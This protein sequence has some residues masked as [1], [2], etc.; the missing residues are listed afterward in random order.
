MN[1]VS[2]WQQFQLKLPHYIS[3]T[4]LN[5]PIGAFLLLWPTLWALWFASNG[6]PDPKLLLIF[7]AGTWLTRSAGCAIN[8]FADRDIDKH[9]RR[10]AERPI[11]SGKIPASDALWITAF[12]M[13]VAFILVL[14]TNKL[15]IALS[16]VA[17]I[18]ACVYPFTKR[19]TH[20]PQVVLG[21]AFSFAVPMAFAAQANAL[22]ATAWVIFFAAVVWAIAYDTFYA[23]A[24]RED[25]LRVGVKSTAIFFGRADLWVI[26]IA[27]AT[28]LSVMFWVGFQYDRGL[29]YFIGLAAAA[30]IAIRQIYITR[31]READK[32]FYAFL[33]NNYLGMVIFLGLAADYLLQG[34]SGT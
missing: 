27:Q 22:P 12:L 28:T 32:C 23:M 18:L 1:Q 24:D 15:T 25:D 29:L 9:I 8:D 19:Y 33:N 14:F 26:A 31:H 30:V 4:R 5:K 6:R 13:F 7:I 17:L 21:A 3:L 11:T 16:F 34:M 2:K 20:F 10:T